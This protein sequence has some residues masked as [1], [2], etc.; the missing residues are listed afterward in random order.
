MKTLIFNAK[1]RY[2]EQHFSC[3]LPAKQLWHNLK[4][5][6]VH[7]PSKNT[8]E[9]ETI[10]ANQL[11]R[12][13]AEG[14][15]SLRSPDHAAYVDQQ[16]ED[17]YQRSIHVH[18]TFNFRH[19]DVDTV[20]KKMWEIHS[21]A[22]GSDN[23]PVSFIK[24]L[25]P[26]ILPLLV[27]LF[28]AII[29]AETFPQCWKKAVVT[30]IPKSTN[31]TEAKDFRPISVLP[32]ASKI[33]EKILLDQISDYLEASDPSLLAKHQ[34]GYRKHYSTTTA[35]T[36]VVH[37]IYAG[38][39]NN[40]C[41]VMVLVDFSVAFNS[42]NHRLLR[43]KLERE[44][45]LSTSA[46]NLLDS[47]LN[48]RSQV[49]KAG[50]VLSDE[51]ALT[52]GTPQGSCLSALLFSLYINSLPNALLCNYHLYADDLQIYVTGPI[53]EIDRLI[54][55]I[56]ADLATIE[57]WATANKLAP[58]PKKT[59]A[60]IFT[61]ENSV[62]THPNIVFCNET[63]VPMD[64]VINLGLHMDN[65]LK[66][67]NQVN[68]VIAKVYGTLRTFRRFSSVLPA[69]TR[70]KLVQAVIGPYFTYCDVVY[71]PGLSAALKD[72]LHRCF[73]SA[74]RFVHRLRSRDT[75]AA[76]RNCVFG[77]DLHVNYRYRICCYMRKGYLLEHPDYIQQHLQHG[78]M[79]RS[80]TLIVPPHSTQL[81]RSVLI[82][83]V[84]VWNSLP[85]ETKMKPT[86]NA[87]KKS[88]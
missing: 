29:D 53:A 67:C 2:A 54:A 26:F 27:H 11:N 25:S 57:H 85:L 5:E 22:T 21:N 24:M 60:I 62:T 82:Y 12:F 35:L 31:P 14:H 68:D 65:H 78:Q 50:N 70:R 64:R 1:Q 87:F 34:S 37:D 19:T 41:T 51:H 23:I 3:D 66:W 44:F 80:R 63:I 18:P 79:Q 74:I 58:N 20:S 84:S 9:N 36:K 86:F 76:V 7:N 73:K 77:R 88:L 49:V 48:R 56:N 10:D 81:R 46:C 61:R 4:R 69:E 15:H 47:F 40:C 32:A 75:T 38:F 72:R 8:S 52:D 59:Q 17:R 83:G 28:N 43:R 39:D 6:G 55:Q 30:P 16:V 13:F 33:L 42:V 45:G 71:T